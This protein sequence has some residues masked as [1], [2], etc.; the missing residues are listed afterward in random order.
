MGTKTT[1]FVGYGYMFSDMVVEALGGE[2]F[3]ERLENYEGSAYEIGEMVSR[4]EDVFFICDGMSGSQHFLGFI[5]AAYDD[6]GNEFG[7][8]FFEPDMDKR[9]IMERVLEN[10]VER[11]GVIR[12]WRLG[13]PSPRVWVHHS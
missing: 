7:Y 13:D 3:I 2:D 9:E 5:F 8:P 12:V 11:L 10:F 1:V 4:G 6:E